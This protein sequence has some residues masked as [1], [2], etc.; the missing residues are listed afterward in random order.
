MANS[1]GYVNV[2]YE[3][4]IPTGY[5]VSDAYPNPFNPSTT[6]NY[7]VAENDRGIPGSGS[8]NW[9]KTFNTLYAIN[10]SKCVTLEMFTQ[11]FVN[12]SKD[13]FTWRNIELDPFEAI[14]KA[15]KFLKKYI[16]D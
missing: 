3:Q 6:L 7:H 15:H 2:Q 11:A 4:T 16:H 1:S 9:E 14:V 8:I 10:Y 13:L 5:A 12:T